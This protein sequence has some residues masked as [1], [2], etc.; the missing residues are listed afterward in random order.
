L[1]RQASDIH[2]DLDFPARNGVFVVNRIEQTRLIGH[3]TTAQDRIMVWQCTMMSTAHLQIEVFSFNSFGLDGRCSANDV[4]PKNT[5]GSVRQMNQQPDPQMN[6]QPDPQ[7]NQ[8]PDPQWWEALAVAP[9]EVVRRLRNEPLPLLAIG[10]SSIVALIGIFAPSQG[11]TYAIVAAV[12]AVLL[13]FFWTVS[14]CFSRPKP[15][16]GNELL[17]HGKSQVKDL[18]AEVKGSSS[19]RVTVDGESDV[20]HVRLGVEEDRSE[21]R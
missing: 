11:G 20:S 17:V 18:R 21:G 14:K 10:T 16:S 6:Q 19:N 3:C 8:Q 9:L 4:S 5:S 12:V 13:A 2:V 7:M 1:I 15:V